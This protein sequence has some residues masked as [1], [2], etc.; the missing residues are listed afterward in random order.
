MKK[1]RQNKNLEPR[2]DSIENGASVEVRPS[3]RLAA[4]SVQSAPALF[5][6]SDGDRHCLFVENTNRSRAGGEGRQG[7]A[8]REGDD[9]SPRTAPVDSNDGQVVGPRSQNRAWDEG[10]V[11]R[12]EISGLEVTEF[13]TAGGSRCDNVDFIVGSGDVNLRGFGYEYSPGFK[14]LP[15]TTQ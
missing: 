4:T 9:A 11:H 14:L 8:T 2:F 6:G 7:R 1:T 12:I 5:F 13:G 15:I 3:I 10:I